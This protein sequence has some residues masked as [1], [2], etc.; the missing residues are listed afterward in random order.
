LWSVVEVGALLLVL[1]GLLAARPDASRAAV[2]EAQLG[3]S[4]RLPI[5]VALAAVSFLSSAAAPF[6]PNRARLV[7]ALATVL[8]VPAAAGWPPFGTSMPTLQS[9][10]IA[11]PGE[12]WL[13]DEDAALFRW[14]RRLQAIFWLA[15]VATVYVPLPRLEWWLE[16]ALR[17]LVIAGLAALVRGSRGLFVNRTLPAAL[18]WCWLLALPI[19][20]LAHAI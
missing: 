12:H 15:L 5:W 18:R 19:A 2:R 17:L 6:P 11:A 10:L 8:A 3:L 9:G 16:L 7:A 13:G 1:P 14:A 20:L 4:G